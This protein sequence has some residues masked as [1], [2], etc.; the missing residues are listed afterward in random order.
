MALKTDE[1]RLLSTQ[2]SV[3][4]GSG[5][6]KE[7]D[8]ADA[9]MFGSGHINP[10]ACDMEKHCCQTA[11][12]PQEELLHADCRVGD[13][14][15]FSACATISETAR[16]L[17]KAVSVSLGL[18]MESNDTSDMD[19]A[20]PTCAA[21]GQ[22]RG[23]YLFGAAPL[24]CPGVQAAVAGYRCPDRDE[25]PLRGQEQLVEMFKSSETAA[26]LQH[27]TST[28]TS[29]DEQNFTLCKADD[30]TSEEI[31]HLDRE[32]TASCPYAQS[33]PGGNL[34]HFGQTATERPCRVYK[35]PDEARDFGEAMENKFGGYQPEQY[36]IKIK[37]EDGESAGALWGSNYNF[38]E[39]NSQV[40]GSRQCMN[41]HGTASNTAFIC[42]PYERSAMRPEQWYPGG[43]LRPPYPNSNYVKTEVGEWLDVAYNDTR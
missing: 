20:L 29:A 30:I 39:Y 33:A 35:P 12:A 22:V 8:N 38:H 23:E 4:N 16:E 25:R 40:W 6:L 1:S 21:N 15:S 43:M 37:S 34:A 28:R 10:L 26:R 32:R 42:N 36:S 7:S 13:S 19:S 17:C 18:A 14:R 5:G 11:A 41:A 9:N 24:N 3:G 27:L 31:D 2:N